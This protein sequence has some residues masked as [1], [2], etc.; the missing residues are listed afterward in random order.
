VLES[1][2]YFY[3][4]TPHIP[5]DKFPIK[6]YGIFDRITVDEA[7]IPRLKED[8]IKILAEVK[9]FGVLLQDAKVEEKDNKSSKKKNTTLGTGAISRYTDKMYS[10]DIDATYPEFT[11][12]HFSPN[13]Q[14]GA[15]PDCLGLGEVLKIDYDKILDP[16][17]PYMEAILP[18]RDSAYGQ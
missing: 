2:E 9:K 13:R 17:S 12:Q 18:W 8:I 11:P 14:E 10:P 4:E 7:K 6:V 16:M 1:V 5:D 15:C 3:L